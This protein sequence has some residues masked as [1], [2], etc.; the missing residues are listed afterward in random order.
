M[1]V[2]SVT[3][4]LGHPW[5]GPGVTAPEAFPS[6]AGSGPVFSGTSGSKA[7]QHYVPGFELQLPGPICLVLLGFAEH[8]MEVPPLPLKKVNL[9]RSKVFGRF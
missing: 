8:C 2:P 4:A 6:A 1:A 5:R 3:Q 7:E 9:E